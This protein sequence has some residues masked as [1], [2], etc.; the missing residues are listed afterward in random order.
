M[1][2]RR[3]ATRADLMEIG[4]IITTVCYL[5][6]FN[7]FILYDIFDNETELVEIW[8]PYLES[9]NYNLK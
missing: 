5:G 8:V 3:I 2:E 4:T 9:I 1:I 6:Y 7:N